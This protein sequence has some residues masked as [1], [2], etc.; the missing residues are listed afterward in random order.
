MVISSGVV[1]LPTSCPPYFDD[2]S[3]AILEKGIR[4]RVRKK[5]KYAVFEGRAQRK[6]Y[7]MFVLFNFIIVVILGFIEGLLHTDLTVNV[8]S[9]I[10]S[11]AVLIP[12]IAVGVRRLHDTDRSGWWMLIS[13]IPIIGMLV[14]LYFMVL[15][16]NAGSNRFGA[17]PKGGQAPT[18]EPQAPIV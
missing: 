12:S 17:N 9:G 8:L 18:V 5:T 4:I 13:L 11:L 16:S 2:A 14:L 7:W 6:E 1:A 10:Y 3:W 15:D